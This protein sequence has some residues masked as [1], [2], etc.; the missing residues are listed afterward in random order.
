MHTHTH[1]LTASQKQEWE[2]VQAQLRDLQ[3]YN[4]QL[5]RQTADLQSSSSRAVTDLQVR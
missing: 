4:T 5:I 1:T 3:A 2:A